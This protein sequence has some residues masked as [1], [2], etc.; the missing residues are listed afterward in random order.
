MNFMSATR[1]IRKHIVI[2]I[3]SW[4]ICAFD[5]Y[6][7][8]ISDDDG[9]FRPRITVL[10]STFPSSDAFSL[11]KGLRYLP[12]MNTRVMYPDKHVYTG[13]IPLWQ[14][15][16]GKKRKMWS[17]GRI[18]SM[19]LIVCPLEGVA[20]NLQDH[21]DYTVLVQVVMSCRQVT[22]LYPSQCWPKSC[23]HMTSLSHNG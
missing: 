11:A 2:K 13:Q 8:A 21:L 23:R 20:F 17:L 4:N 3:T 22:S 7:L 10:K 9:F 5:V 12:K 19:K 18:H 15:L 1:P 6:R 16:F 14:D